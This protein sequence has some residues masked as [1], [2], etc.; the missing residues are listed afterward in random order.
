MRKFILLSFILSGLLVNIKLNGQTLSGSPEEL[1]QLI[2]DKRFKEAVVLGNAMLTQDSLNPQVYYCLGL[3]YSNLKQYTKACSALEMSDKLQPGNKSV[4][5]NLA[6]CYCEVADAAAAE[7]LIED[8]LKIDSTDTFIWLQLAQVYQRQAEIDKAAGIF[9]R[10][11][12]DD[13]LNIWF[14]RQIGN[15]LARNERFQA[16]I[17]YLE[18]VVEADS[19]DMGSY[20]RLGQAY[21][22]L[23]LVD[24]IPVLDKAIRQDSS[25]SV[26][27][28]YRGGLQL[29][30]GK[31]SL[32]E[33]DLLAAFE[34]GDSSNFVSRH[35]GLSQFH[36]SKYQEALKSFDRTVKIDSL[37]T[38]AWY[39]LGFCYKWTED[40]PKAID[41]LNR[42]LKMAI[43][44]STASIYSGLG[45]FYNLQRD[46]K[47]AMI[48]Y[49]KSLE[50]NPN[51]AYPYSQL[52][53]LVEQTSRDKELAKDYYE[54][55]LFGYTGDDRNLIEYVKSR[56]Q[57][58]NEKLFME[59]KIKKKE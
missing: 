59:G 57:A 43:P 4:I 56:I 47:N 7:I 26:L 29:A 54:K 16:A 27:F 5:L 58:I 36:Q 41:C 35:L 50:Y 33:A 52:G 39:Y 45:L 15:M 25:E 11:W 8:L 13:S 46:L 37:D 19:S 55:F 18:M 34:L 32:A 31:F 20:M 9:N 22:N 6:D 38:E 51:D 48:Y 3:A 24:K 42:A 53:L 28:R 40:L 1:N 21:I 2:L 12:A 30:D 49:K 23:K 10:L 14:P 44:P 17:P